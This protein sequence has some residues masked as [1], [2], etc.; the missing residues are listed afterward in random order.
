MALYKT[1]SI[2]FDIISHHWPCVWLSIGD[3][4]SREEYLSRPFF[5]PTIEA[6]KN[7]R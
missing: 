4:Y 1:S 3:E 6:Y 5:N 7:S 2:R